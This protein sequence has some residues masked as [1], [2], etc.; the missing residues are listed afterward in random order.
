MN[1][2]AAGIETR[3]YG[4]NSRTNT[5]ILSE[6]LRTMIITSLIAGAF[7]FFSWVRS[8][9][10]NTGYESQKLFALEESLL[11]T[12]KKLILEEATLRNPKRIDTLARTELNMAPLQPNQIILTSFRN[13]VGG[14]VMAMANS[15][16][17]NAGKNMQARASG[18]NQTD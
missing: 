15:N 12:Q 10:I 16:A 9:I 11:R 18:M 1:D 2:W 14:N 6:L 13:E 3:N 8:Q 7:L 17:I 5:G 4:I